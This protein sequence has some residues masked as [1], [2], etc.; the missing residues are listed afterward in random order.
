MDF[1]QMSVVEYA[2]DII[3]ECQ[4]QPDGIARLVE[5]QVLVLQSL[6]VHVW[7]FQNIGFGGE[8]NFIV[9]VVVLQVK[10]QQ[11]KSVEFMALGS[12]L[13]GP[14]ADD[15]SKPAFATSIVSEMW[16]LG[17]RCIL[18]TCR[19]KAMFMTRIS[20]QVRDANHLFYLKLLFSKS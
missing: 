10:Y 15:T 8:L 12:P 2:L 14:Q 3:E 6:S 1:V 5:N 19:S 16:V 11:T 7:H 13:H 4:D 20:L 18:T 17:H 9:V